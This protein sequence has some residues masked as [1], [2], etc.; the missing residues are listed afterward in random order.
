MKG[1]ECHEPE[2]RKSKSP[3]REKGDAQG[4]IKNKT[5][6]S[7]RLAGRAVEAMS[8]QVRAVPLPRTVI[9]TTCE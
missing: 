7:N 2:E 3:L 9:G 8:K 6:I 4:D 5:S 1:S